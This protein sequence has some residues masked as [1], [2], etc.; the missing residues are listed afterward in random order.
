[1]RALRTAVFVSAVIAA[2]AGVSY[3]AILP[4]AHVV[5]CPGW[6]ALWPVLGTMAAVEAVFVLLW[7]AKYRRFNRVPQP[8]RPQHP[9]FSPRGVFD[10]FVGGQHRISKWIC[11]RVCGLRA[12]VQLET[13]T[14]LEGVVG[15]RRRGG[16]RTPYTPQSVQHT[17]VP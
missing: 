5:V 2:L 9:S 12:M 10:R 8:H 17:Q 13:G 15:G 4:W 3:A 11:I 16:H 6:S 1:M 14:L 7:L